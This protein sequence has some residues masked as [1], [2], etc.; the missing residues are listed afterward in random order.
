MKL[1]DI[2]AAVSGSIV[3]KGS[4]FETADIEYVTAADLMSEVLIEDKENMILV[5][6]LTSE[7]VARTADIVDAVA[8]ILVNAKQPQPEMRTLLEEMD[9]IC[10]SSPLS[11]YEC[12]TQIGKL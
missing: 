3:Y 5:T 7:Q 11:M 8:V 9:I 6:A 10:L 1:K 2:S 12:C 4:K